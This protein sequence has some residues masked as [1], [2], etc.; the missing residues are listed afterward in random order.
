MIEIVEVF[1]GDIKVGTLAFTKDNKVAFQ[2]TEEWRDILPPL[3]H[4]GFEAGASRSRTI[5]SPVS[6]S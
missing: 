3:N 5:I 6:T 1:A 2:Y 4:K